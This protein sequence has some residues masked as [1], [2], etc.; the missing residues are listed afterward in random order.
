MK[1]K[2]TIL[3][4]ISIAAG[5]TLLLN[6]FGFV[7]IGELKII[8]IFLMLYGLISVYAL[9][10]SERKGGIFFGSVCFLT[11]VMMFVSATCEILGKSKIALP[12][13]LL[14]TGS[15]FLMLFIDNNREKAFLIIASILIFAGIFTTYFFESI[16]IIF[17]A[18]RIALQILEYWHIIFIIAGIG[19]LLNKRKDN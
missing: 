17:T 19:V 5:F 3:S 14:I 11:G 10:G 1:N 8:S 4:I 7:N 12:S 18:N 16:K 15:S 13:M 6:Y 9:F 2:Q